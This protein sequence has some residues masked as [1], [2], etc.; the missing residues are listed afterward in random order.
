[1]TRRLTAITLAITVMAGCS[2][3]RYIVTPADEITLAATDRVNPDAEGRASPIVAH[4]LQLADRTT[5]DNLDFDAAFHSAERLL[6]EDLVERR[7]TVL[8]P[9]QT[10]EER[11][12]LGPGTRFIAVV[13]AYRNID[14][15]RWKR[16][17][18]VAPD[19]YYDHRITLTRDAVVLGEVT[20]QEAGTD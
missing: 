8:Q 7:E 5:F 3:N 2:V 14:A 12:E 13:G 17:Y 11:V 19:W 15:A 6:G 1:M 20:K 9:G 4:I 16:V 18:E 10:L